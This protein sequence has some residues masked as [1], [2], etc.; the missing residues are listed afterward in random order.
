MPFTRRRRNATQF[1]TLDTSRCQAC[2]QCV[3]ECHRKVIG[4]VSILYHRHVV[5][6]D[7]GACGGCLKCVRTCAHGA[8]T[9]NTDKNKGGG[10]EVTTKQR[11]F[12][13]RAFVAVVL[14]ASGALLPVS[15]IMNHQLQMEPITMTRHFWMAVHNMS[16]VLFTVACVTHCTLNWKPIVRHLHSTARAML[17]KEATVALALVIAVV[18]LFAR[19]AFLVR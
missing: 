13:T 4:K 2:W 8:F 9:A 7:A 6:T 19:H 11:S 5:I 14:L 15:G 3:E 12:N 1:V 17:T 18:G 16:A 10:M